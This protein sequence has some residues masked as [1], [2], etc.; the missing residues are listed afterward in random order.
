M[1]SHNEIGGGSTGPLQRF[2]FGP[3]EDLEMEPISVAIL[4][5]ANL[6]KEL[7]VWVTPYVLKYIP[8][9]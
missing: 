5:L 2:T 8:F 6:E 4:L 9:Y 1:S 3:L 7:T